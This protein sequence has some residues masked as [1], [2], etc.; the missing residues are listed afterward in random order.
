LQKDPQIIV[1]IIP[2]FVQGFKVL[3]AGALDAVVA[4]RWVGSYGI[5]EKDISGLELIEERISRSHSAIAVKKGNVKL[6]E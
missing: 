2:D 5:A 3:A 1:K 4:D 6:Q